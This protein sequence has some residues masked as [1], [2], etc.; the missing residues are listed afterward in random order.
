MCNLLNATGAKIA[1]SERPRKSF[2]PKG[3]VKCEGVVSFRSQIARDVACLLDLD[4]SVRSWTCNPPALLITDKY[5]VCDFSVLDIWDV[6]TLVD[7]SDH[8]TDVPDQILR[9]AASKSGFE[10]RRPDKGD[11]YSGCR[12]RNARDLLR[13]SNYRVSLGDR[14]RLLAALEENGS[15]TVVECLSAFTE[16]K[17]IG[18]LA[19]MILTGFVEVDLDESLIGPGTQVKRIS[20]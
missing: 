13:Y 18:G 14:V 3:T 2:F 8:E 4:P 11:V 15:L 6:E 9:A 5:F 1:N 7:A 19:S 20:A 17:P 16:T 10:F 12:L